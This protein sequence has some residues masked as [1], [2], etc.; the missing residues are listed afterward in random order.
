MSVVPG[1]V[2]AWGVTLRGHSRRQGWAI[3]AP[4]AS[5][6]FVPW[7]LLNREIRLSGLRAHGAAAHVKRSP[8][9]FEPVAGK[10][11]PW[12]I[13]LPD[14]QAINLRSVLIEGTM[15]ATGR[16][17]AS[18]DLRKEL[19]GGEFEITGGELDWQQLQIVAGPA[20]PVRGGSVTGKFAVEAFVPSRTTLVHKLQAVTVKS[21]TVYVYPAL[22]NGGAFIG[23][24]RQMEAYQRKVLNNRTR[25]VADGVSHVRQHLQQAP[26]VLRVRAG[27][28]CLRAA[29]RGAERFA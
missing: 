14:L 2:M 13:T 21:G 12:T 25:Q 27:R 8:V 3:H 28:P 23:G 11:H 7:A 22:A 19:S 4:R 18:M 9:R 17:S 15:T 20:A 29:R 1:H 5:V 26:L 6:W 24:P 10:A 16:A